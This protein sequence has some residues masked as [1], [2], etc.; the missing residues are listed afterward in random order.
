ME[1]IALKRKA[2]F[3]S[4]AFLLNYVQLFLFFVLVFFIFTFRRGLF[5]TVAVL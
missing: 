3:H 2:S 1:F 5:F 4:S